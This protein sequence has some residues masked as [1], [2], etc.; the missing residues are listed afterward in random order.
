MFNQSHLSDADRSRHRV[1]VNNYLNN[2]PITS[3]TSQALI[4]GFASES[5]DEPFRING[6]NVNPDRLTLYVQSI[7]LSL[8][9]L[10]TI[11]IPP[12]TI[13]PQVSIESQ[14]NAVDILEEGQYITAS[15]GDIIYLDYHLPEYP[16]IKYKQ[17][18]QF[19]VEENSDI[20]YAMW[21]EVVKGW[22]PFDATAM[23]QAG[24]LSVDS[25]LFNERIVRIKLSFQ[26]YSGV[27]M[28]VFGVE[29]SVK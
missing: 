11:K 24:S 20:N 9:S 22:E 3:S 16:G 10:G 5:T 4:L 8:D 1:L 14:S 19:N 29:G 27:R 7:P 2:A 18:N 21:D 6:K 17:I 12:G 13:K 26:E 28:P 15:K 25:F 23:N